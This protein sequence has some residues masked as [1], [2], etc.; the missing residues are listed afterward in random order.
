[1][2]PYPDRNA[3]ETS[4]IPFFD[5]LP[6]CPSAAPVHSLSKRPVIPRAR[7]AKVEP[8]FA[9]DRAPDVEERMI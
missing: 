5:F 3:P 4:V 6:R 9:S 8:G 2:L 1:V 7:S